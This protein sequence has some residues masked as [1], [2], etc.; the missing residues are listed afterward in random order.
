V[1]GVIACVAL[2][3]T[4]ASAAAAPASP[5]HLIVSLTFDDGYDNQ[6][7]VA[8]PMLA[9]HGMVGTFFVPSGFV[10]STG[11]MTW[12]Q[13][14]ALAAAGNEIGGHTIHHY[15]LT[16]VTPAV[17][18]QEICGDRNTLLSHGLSVTDFA[19]PDGHYNPALE[20]IA[21]H[22]GYNS[23]RTTSWNGVPCWGPCTESIPPKDPYA[24]NIVAFGGDQTLAAIESDITT[25]E[26]Y[27]GWAQILIHRV[28]DACA[29]GA[30]S[31]SDLSALLDWLQ[32]RSA[33]GTVVETVAQVIGG[34]V[35]PAVSATAA[36][37][38]P[39]PTLT[40]ATGGSGSVALQWSAPAWD[41]G[42]AVTGYN[43]Y[44]GTS[45]GG[46]TLL[47]QVGNVT[48]Y[49]DSTATNGTKYFYT[50]SA[51]NS[52]GEGAQSGELSALPGAW[53]VVASDQFGR[54]VAT[55]FGAPDVG[56]PWVVSST[57]QTQVV[58]GEGDIYGWTAGNQDVQASMP[59]SASDMD[60]LG[61]VRL[62]AQDPV[63][64]NYQARVVARAQ[65]DARNG[66]T[67]VITHTTAGA[68]KWSVQRVVNAGGAGTLS[69]GSGTL[70]ASGA[71]GT[72]WWVRIDAQGTQIKARF[73]QDGTPEPTTWKVNT[74]DS[75]WASGRAAFG[76]YTGAAIT[77][78]YPDTGFDSF[79]YSVLNFTPVAPMAPSLTSVTGSDG[80]VGLQWSAP[81]W[82]G[83]SAVSG[84][85]VYRGTAS[86]GET[87]LAQVGNVT[88]YTDSSVTNGTTYYYTVSAVNSA[89][90]GAQSGE[91]SAT[92]AGVPVVIA[93][94]QFQRS[95]A[96]GFGTPDLGPPWAVSSTMQTQVAN[97]EGDIYGWT[98]GNRDEQA[99]IPVSANDMDVV[100]RIRLSA[101]D[102]V[103]ANYQARVVARAQ[104]DARNGYSAIITHT[105]AGA[106]RWSLQRVVNAGGDGTLVLG[107]GTLLA[108]GA[109]GTKWWVRIDAQGTQIKARFWQ[110][111]T[112]EP[113]TW[114]VSATDS[115]WA[116]GYP[117]VGVYVGSGLAAPFPDTGFS[118]FTATSL[119]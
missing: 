50:V 43:V 103:G 68:V 46:E 25:A 48:S 52:V 33:Q 72:K 79:T 70:L 16:T 78:P 74:T 89:G 42:S 111:G 113:T 39:A 1:A 60:V 101:Q 105:Q 23:A 40:G 90:E 12:A 76:V 108:S 84:Y 117:A 9:A 20:L 55:G 119:P 94:D 99:W 75:Q 26:T 24:T 116:G 95:V 6:A 21:Q 32:P 86:G 61:E 87:L 71:A 77:A 85:D 98:T 97:G 53:T 65:T 118:N 107:S 80:S 35:N 19:Y 63:G 31:P 104:A 81:A 7:T 2:A 115:Q 110:D 112:I 88:S 41:G 28:C 64:G 57:K 83:G 82:N 38:P 47:A 51:V 62:S 10:G 49:T 59:I 30:M 66:Y 27:G 45:S 91:Q 100:A 29:A 36:V 11:Y 54:T 102:P 92:P 8:G 5:N 4:L 96:A 67:A 114:K 17:A 13:V 69:L 22:C 109:A 18:E 56:P 106:L 73:W 58:N 3:T 15:D 44:R 14:S 37:A 34:S 93:S